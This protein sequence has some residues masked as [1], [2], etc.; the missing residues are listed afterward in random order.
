MRSV[1]YGVLLTVFFVCAGSVQA[2]DVTQDTYRITNVK[3]GTGSGGECGSS[4]M[5]R[6]GKCCDCTLGYG[7]ANTGKKKCWMEV[8]GKLTRCRCGDWL[9]NRLQPL[10]L[11]SVEQGGCYVR[12][13]EC[14][15][16][17]TGNC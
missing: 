6:D 2:A 4:S 15:P 11:K 7:E 8:S 17:G 5:M 10:C 3:D 13:Q 14:R 12:G 1:F 9:C 16:D